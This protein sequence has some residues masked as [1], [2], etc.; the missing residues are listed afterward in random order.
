MTLGASN[1]TA[2]NPTVKS[3]LLIGAYNGSSER[4]NGQ[5]ASVM[6][7]DRVLS[8]EER[9]QNYYIGLRRFS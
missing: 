2:F 7:Y 1:G 3:Y 4:F 5:M 8:Y 6:I 9:L